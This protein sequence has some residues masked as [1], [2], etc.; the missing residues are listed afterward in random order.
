MLVLLAVGGIT[1]VVWGTMLWLSFLD[2]KQVR[3][4][5]RPVKLS[6]TPFKTAEAE[7]RSTEI[8]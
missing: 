7:H 2:E 1:C 6:K 5:R 3:L 8:S 4:L